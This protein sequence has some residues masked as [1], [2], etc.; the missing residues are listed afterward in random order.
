MLNFLAILSPNHIKHPALLGKFAAKRFLYSVQMKM[1]TLE[2]GN[3][4][5]RKKI[6]VKLRDL[7]GKG[8]KGWI[9]F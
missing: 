8:A 5:R 9:Y 3:D 6:D 4:F 7:T 2:I 1:M